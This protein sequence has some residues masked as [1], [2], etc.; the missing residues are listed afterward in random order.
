MDTCER[1][2]LLRLLI[3]RKNRGLCR[4]FSIAYTCRHLQTL[5]D[6]CRNTCVFC[7]LVGKASYSSSGMHCINSACDLSRISWD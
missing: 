3:E 1:V 4:N 7:A 6:T 2:R 5:A